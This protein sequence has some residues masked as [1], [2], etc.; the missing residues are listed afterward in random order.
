MSNCLICL[1]SKGNLLA[2]SVQWCQ[3]RP[4]QEGQGQVKIPSNIIAL[5]HFILFYFAF[6]FTNID[7]GQ[8]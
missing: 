1:F 8:R 6:F 5:N 4:M 7:K 3:M 2:W